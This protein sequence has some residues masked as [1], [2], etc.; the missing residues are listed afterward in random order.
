LDFSPT[1]S[2]SI[3]LDLNKVTAQ[4]VN[5]NCTLTVLRVEN[6]VGGAVA[7]EIVSKI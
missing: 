5:V 7:G 3:A 6:V 2:F 1:D 4:E